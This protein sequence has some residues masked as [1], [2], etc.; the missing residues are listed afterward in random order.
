M[1]ASALPGTCLSGGTSSAGATALGDVD[2]EAGDAA[3]RARA[4]RSAAMRSIGVRNGPGTVNDSF[5]SAFIGGEDTG[6]GAGGA[7]TEW[8]SVC[9]VADDA[10]Y[11]S[12]GVGEIESFSVFTTALA[13]RGGAEA[14]GGTGSGTLGGRR[15]IADQRETLAGGRRADL[16]PW[17]MYSSSSPP[18][19]SEKESLS[20]SSSRRFRFLDASDASARADLAPSVGGIGVATARDDAT[21]GGAGAGT[22]ESGESV[23]CALLSPCPSLRRTNFGNFSMMNLNSSLLTRPLLRTSFSTERTSVRIFSTAWL[24]W[25]KLSVSRLINII[26]PIMT[27]SIGEMRCAKGFLVVASRTRERY[28]RKV[29]S[30]PERNFGGTVVVRVSHFSM[31][32]DVGGTLH[33]GSCSIR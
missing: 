22:R 2:T 23:D 11:V 24:S 4:A 3:V 26:T 29:S 32:W 18:P 13:T 33:V 12:G 16:C 8:P 21:G 9:G 28:T 10:R 20:S 7:D 1:G 19:G 6:R 25:A 14:G 17:G 5:F 27:N 15:V 31:V 30:T